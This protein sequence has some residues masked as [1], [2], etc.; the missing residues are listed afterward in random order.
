MERLLWL[1]QLSANLKYE[2]GSLTTPEGV[3]YIGFRVSIGAVRD[4]ANFEMSYEDVK[5]IFKSNPNNFKVLEERKD[6]KLV[7][8]VVD[9]L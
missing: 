4:P 9:T 5:A 8:F 6:G 2:K 7:R 3:P 1:L